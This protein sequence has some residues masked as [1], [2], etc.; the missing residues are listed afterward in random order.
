MQYFFQLV[1]ILASKSYDT[2]M[3]TVTNEIL[4]KYSIFN[5]QIF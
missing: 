4:Y 5:P 3:H 2:H 1:S